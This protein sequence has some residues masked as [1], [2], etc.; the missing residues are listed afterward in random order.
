V[1]KI[2]GN[3][4]GD[5]ITAKTGFNFGKIFRFNLAVLVA[6]SIFVTGCFLYH[7]LKH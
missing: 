4:V 5:N 3:A 2:Y 6:G 7:I 1:N